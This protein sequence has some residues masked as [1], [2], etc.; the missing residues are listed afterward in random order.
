MILKGLM[1]SL[2]YW[3]DKKI[4]EEKFNSSDI[5]EVCSE[6]DTGKSIFYWNTNYIKCSETHSY[7]DPYSIFKITVYFKIKN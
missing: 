2:F 7:E 4:T 1:P 6:Y 5:I 3:T